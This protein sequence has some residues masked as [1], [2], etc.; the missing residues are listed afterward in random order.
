MKC[1][2]C[3]GT[4]DG[5]HRGDRNCSACNGTGGVCDVCGEAVEE[6]GLDLCASCKAE[7]EEKGEE[8]GA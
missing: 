6:A 2:C 7:Q 4:G 5:A 1:E 8:A 3:N